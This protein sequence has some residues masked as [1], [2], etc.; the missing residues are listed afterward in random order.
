M[1][2]SFDARIARASELRDKYPAARELLDFYCELAK[3]QQRIFEEIQATDPIALAAYLPD[4]WNLVRRAGPALLA[5]VLPAKDI[6][7]AEWHHEPLDERD[8]FYARVLL[9][10]FAERLRARA[11]PDAACSAWEAPPG[12]AGA[13]DKAHQHST[14]PFC[15]SK[16]LAAILRGEGEGAKRSLLCSLCSTEWPFRRILCPECGEEDREKLPI[17]TTS[18]VN[19][20]RAEA[21]DS[22]RSYIKSIDLTRDGHAI[23]VVDE[24]ATIAL[25]VWADEHGY[26]KIESNLLG[27]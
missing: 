26:S 10:P 16:P 17:Y 25:T 22:C 23:P 6:L 3:F 15:R 18:E 4:L 11:L 1:K 27:L 5:E 2:A 21:C 7:N 12:R 20:V 9:Q 14:C 8:R 13:I 19:H 24:I